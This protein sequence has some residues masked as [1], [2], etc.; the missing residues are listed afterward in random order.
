[1]T[2]LFVSVVSFA[3]NGARGDGPGSSGGV[4]VIVGVALAV[5]LVGFLLVMFFRRGRPRRAA[6]TRT[7]DH[8]GHAGRVSEF[9]ED[10]GG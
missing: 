9:R 7:P 5:L 10:A 3:A 6:M 2:D 1:M 8:A 4:F